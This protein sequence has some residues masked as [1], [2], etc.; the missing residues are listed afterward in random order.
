MDSQNGG[1]VGVGLKDV[2][3]YEADHNKWGFCSTL[4]V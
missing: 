4:Q 3:L 2:E 1:R